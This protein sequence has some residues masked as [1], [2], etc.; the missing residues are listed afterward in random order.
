MYSSVSFALISGAVA[1]ASAAISDKHVPAVATFLNAVFFRTAGAAPRAHCR[2][3]GELFLLVVHVTFCAGERLPAHALND[4]FSHLH[5]LQD[6]G[7]LGGVFL[8]GDEI[9]VEHLL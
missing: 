6:R 1:R 8:L 2:F 4:R 5:L 3:S 7:L 9:R